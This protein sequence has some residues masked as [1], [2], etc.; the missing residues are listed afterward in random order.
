M[1][2]FGALALVLLLDRNGLKKANSGPLAWS[3]FEGVA[4]AADGVAA[5]AVVVVQ[6]VVDGDGGV[7]GG[8]AAALAP[9]APTLG[10]AVQRLLLYVDLLGFRAQLV[11]ALPRL[12]RDVIQGLFRVIQDFVRAGSCGTGQFFYLRVQL[13]YHPFEALAALAGVGA[14]VLGQHV[15][16]VPIEGHPLDLDGGLLLQQRLV[17]IGR[18]WYVA[19]RFVHRQEAPEGEVDG[20]QRHQLLG[21]I[22]GGLFTGVAHIR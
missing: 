22:H 4:A 21:R 5:V 15:L 6:E 2:D 20:L 7:G 17:R 16:H 9:V 8:E 14:N 1:D 12:V 11:H 18:M 10:D 3:A 19:E 13:P